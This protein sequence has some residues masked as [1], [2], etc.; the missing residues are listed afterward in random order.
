M[1]LHYLYYS[2]DAWLKNAHKA[3]VQKISLDAYSGCPNR[4]GTISH[5]GCTFCNADGSGSGLM[6]HGLNLQE[7]WTY[8]KNKFAQSD[9]LK[10]TKHFLAYLQSY[11]N[12]YGNIKRLEELTNQLSTLNDCVGFSIGTRP[13]C[14]DDNKLSLLENL[15]FLTKWIEFGVQSMNDNTLKIIN[16]GHT[17]EISKNAIIKSHQHNLNVCVHI[18]A[19]LPNE[20]ENDFLDTIKKVC[21]LPIQGIK[22]HGLYVCKNTPLAHAYFEKK[23]TPLSQ[24]Q[25]INLICKA[26]SIIPSPICIHRL[27]ADP[28]QDELIAPEWAK[29]KGHI[30]REIETQLFQ[31]GLWQGIKAD[32]PLE[33]PYTAIYKKLEK[34]H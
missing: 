12:T 14:I 31:D 3:K 1:K 5:G 33:N 11:S 19:G 28:Q 9:R 15:P 2:F 22:L 13:D 8:W 29:L 32:V 18:M 26:L 21:E 10:N 17:A 25:Y 34:L 4:D 24:E 23:Y 6:K 27:T 7:Q 20:T 16:R 30:V